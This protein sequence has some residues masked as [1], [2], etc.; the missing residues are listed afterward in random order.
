MCVNLFFIIVFSRL[1][2]KMFVPFFWFAIWLCNKKPTSLPS[3]IDVS[4][5]YPITDLFYFNNVSTLMFTGSVDVLFVKKESVV[6]VF[7]KNIYVCVRRQ[8]C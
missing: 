3:S 5:A 1:I 2:K 8:C 6:F 4:S 7:L